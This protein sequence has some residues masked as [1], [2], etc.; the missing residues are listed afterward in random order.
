[1]ARGRPAVGFSMGAGMTRTLVIDALRM[2]WF[3][4]RPKRGSCP[5]RNAPA[6][7]QERASGVIGLTPAE[8]AQ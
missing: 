1:M 6:N 2:G 8:K 3:R 5:I 4:G 7:R